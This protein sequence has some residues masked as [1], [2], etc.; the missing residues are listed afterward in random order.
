[1][2]DLSA[3][4]YQ[5]KDRVLRLR[6]WVLSPKR[7]HDRRVFSLCFS[8]TPHFLICANNTKGKISCWVSYG[9]SGIS[10]NNSVTANP[11]Q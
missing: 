5:P 11:Q 6:E 8:L 1:M 7:I 4:S 2:T 10:Q 3:E 9:T